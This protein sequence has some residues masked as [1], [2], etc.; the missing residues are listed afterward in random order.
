MEPQ[1]RISAQQYL[2]RSAARME[3]AGLFFG[4]GTDNAWD[5]AC[6][7]LETLLKRDGV[8]DIH[9]DLPLSPALVAQAD[10]MLAQR[11]STRT[12]LAYLLREAWFCGVPFYV[13]ERVL[14]PRSPIAELIQAG[15][16]P[17]LQQ[18]PRRVLD[19]CA[20]GG[21]IGIA[22][23]LA[24]EE[25]EVVLSD[26]SPE[27]LEVARMNVARFALQNRVQVLQSDLC[28]AVP[29]RFDLIVSNPPYV[30]QDE[31]DTLPGEFKREPVLGLVSAREGLAIPLR[32]LDQAV[33]K[34][35]PG[36]MLVLETGATWELLAATR[37]D[38]PFLWLEF[39]N[40]GEG[41]CALTREQLLATL[42]P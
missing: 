34:L 39:E 2:E 10:A 25:A 14:V 17:L 12:P 33:D 40:G 6:W 7:L 5:E 23:A 37:P 32:I 36:G 16:A 21:C 28:A 30:A 13:D 20:G 19:L 35:D 9:P 41:V 22:C 29:G 11:L 27:A 18:A 38:L 1:Q 42:P 8:Q 3:E 15:F 26:I 4:H 31:Y 24:F